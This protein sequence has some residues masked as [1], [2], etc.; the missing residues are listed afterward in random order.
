MIDLLYYLSSASSFLPFRS[1][2]FI[3]YLFLFSMYLAM[4]S[5]KLPER[6]K[7]YSRQYRKENG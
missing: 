1:E 7:L 5:M 2:T 3:S 4:I 6:I